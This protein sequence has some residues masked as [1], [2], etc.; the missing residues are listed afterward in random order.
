MRS[1][2]GDPSGRSP[3]STFKTKVPQSSVKKRTFRAIGVGWITFVLI[4]LG[5][6]MVAT[7]IYLLVNLRD[8]QQSVVQSVRE[9][10]M[11]AVFQTHREA[12]RLIESIL[13]TQIAPSDTGLESVSL[14]FDL[15]YSRMTLLNAGI[16]VESFHGSEQL[17]SLARE[18]SADII[19][20]ADQIDAV[21]GNTDAFVATLPDILDRAADI[22]RVSNELVVATNEK[23]G[24]ARASDR[25]E[26]LS[27]YS[28]L[29]GFVAV[30]TLLFIAT[31]AL[32]FKQLKEILKTHRRMKALSL[33]N[34]E[35]AKL[36]EAASEAKSM[37]LATMSHEIRT[38]LNGIIGAA[39]LL[40]TTELS[41][42]QEKRA[43]TIWRSGHILLDVINDILDYSNL[44]ANGITFQNAPVALPDVSGLLADVF[45]ERI[46]DAGL[47]LTIDLPPLVVATD[48]MRLRQ[49]MLNLVGNAIKFT[50]CGGITVAG[51]YRDTG[52]L[53]ISVTD[54]GIGISAED[55]EKLFQNFSQIED[56]T[57]RRFGGTGLGLAISKRIVTG[58]GGAIGV[59]SEAGKGS[60]FWITLPVA[61]LGRAAPEPLPAMTQ[62]SVKTPK[63]DLRILL[64]EDNA[65]NREV[66]IAL[67]ESFGAQVTT[68]NDGDAA[69]KTGTA[70][71]FDLVIMDLQMPVMD[72]ISAT[73]ALRTLGVQ[74]PIVG[75]T[76]NAFAEDR[77]RC[78]DA[79]MDE[80]VAKPVTRDKIASVLA[81]FAANFVV[82][83]EGNAVD[84]ID[85]DQLSPVLAELGSD[86]F[87]QLLDQLN[88]DGQALL[89]NV[90][91]K[92]DGQNDFDA[93]LHA[94]KGAAA[95]L[96]LR[97]VG[98]VSQEMRDRLTA[99]PAEFDAL[100]D[101]LSRSIFDA[102][103]AVA[104]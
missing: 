45:R 12:S 2:S 65:I 7:T 70:T 79:G 21:S 3:G 15:V 84:L 48:V 39:D 86:L 42:K 102:R 17:Q 90:A 94:I 75:L 8:R 62:K 82:Q 67:F 60:V 10:A 14:H 104:A 78:L 18:V 99:E 88:D 11:W 97:Q 41:E 87:L 52:D 51:E 43:Q 85:M 64:A 19:A 30:A 91:E 36:A 71:S 57:T 35:S 27:E 26:L 1:I 32:Q 68:A 53:F 77:R 69:V 34:A 4:V 89:R 40:M 56:S 100:I 47:S 33:R 23:L 55:Q 76:A 61:V 31:I 38:P 95:T 81:Q 58:M 37:F 46:A 50:P 6:F 25:D 74:T 59:D 28:Q 73:K 63:Y 80:F 98:V 44:D 66:A 93:E 29:A 13:S 103:Q 9:D 5:V 22:Q 49:V 16:F 83:D 20:L 101:L 24:I 96:G 72:G 54:S 92:G